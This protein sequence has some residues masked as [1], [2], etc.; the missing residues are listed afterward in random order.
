MNSQ[1]YPS[2]HEPLPEISA[3][4]IRLILKMSADEQIQLYESL[5]REQS[6][7]RDRRREHPRKKYFM[8]ADCVIEE[9][10]HHGYIKNI[11][12]SGLFIEMESAKDLTP[13]VP[14]T[15]TFSHPDCKDY[16]KTKGK[17]ARVEKTGIGVHLND[18][19]SLFN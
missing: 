4:L 6:N 2:H 7:K 15:L 9:R 13:G 8:T 18:R 12:P 3:K 11:S 1:V 17:I 14:V 10:L 16:V 19:I 5:M